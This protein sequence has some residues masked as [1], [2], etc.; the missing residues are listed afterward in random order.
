MTSEQHQE[1][2]RLNAG[3]ASLE[4]SGGV[5]LDTVRELALTGVDRISIGHLTKDIKATDY[6]MRFQIDE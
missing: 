4:I 1:S 6:S 2:V 3:R 5:T